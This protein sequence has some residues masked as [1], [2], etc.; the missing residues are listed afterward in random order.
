M[1]I[2]VTTNTAL[3]T[4]SNGDGTPDRFD[5]YMEVVSWDHAEYDGCTATQNW[6]GQHPATP[7]DTTNL[8]ER[9]SVWGNGEAVYYYA[10]SL[11]QIL[12]YWVPSLTP[13]GEALNYRLPLT[14]LFKHYEWSLPTSNWSDVRVAGIYMGIETQGR[15][16]TWFEVEDWR[17]YEVAP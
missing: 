12:G 6:W 2:G 9:R 17:L 5:R 1:R 15:G 3:Q 8:Y 7:C 10:S 16:I 14:K 11:N 4:D 13:G